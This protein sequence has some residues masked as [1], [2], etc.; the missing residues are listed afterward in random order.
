MADIEIRFHKDM[1][2]LSAPVAYTLERQGI[3]TAHDAEFVNLIEPEAVEDALRLEVMAGAQCIVTNTEGLCEA[4]LAHHRLEDRARDLAAAALESVRS[5]KPQH[6]ICEVGTCAL[7]LDASDELSREQH[8][9]QYRDAVSAFGSDDFDAV[10]LSGLRSE[11]DVRCAVEGARR[12]TARP[13]FAVVDL[14]EEGRAAGA[15]I[16]ELAEALSQA[17][18]AGISCAAPCDAVCDAVR[19]LAACVDVP[20]LV[21]FVV[22]A[23][24]AAEKKRAMLGAAIPGKPYALPDDLAHA[25]IAVRAAGA[26]FVRAVGQAAPACTGA[27]AVA[28]S[29]ADCLR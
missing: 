12:A 4:R 3:D 2:V 7:P 13:V 8:I 26:Q 29:G 9:A 1:L 23:A 25:A 20:V 16:E 5:C 11:A 21:Q 22:R 15:S 10:L 19:R 27:L 24:T 6:V 14:D 17:D 28:V 18:V